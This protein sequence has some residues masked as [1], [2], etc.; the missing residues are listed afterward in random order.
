M[1]ACSLIEENASLKRNSCDDSSKLGRRGFGKICSLDQVDII[2]T[3]SGDSETMV[4]RIK[5]TGIAVI[6]V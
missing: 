5:E 6:M 4:K 3:D 2:I 1:A